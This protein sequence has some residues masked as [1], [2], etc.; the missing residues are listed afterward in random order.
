MQITPNMSDMTTNPSPKQQGFYMPAEWVRHEATWLTYPHNEE[1]WPGKIETIFN[2]Y[3]LFIKVLAEDERVCINVLN[4]AMRQQVNEDLHAIGV[5]MDRITLCVTP[6]ND[7]WCRDHG[8]AFLLN[9][10]SSDRYAIVNWNYNAWGGK[11]PCELDNQVPLH[12]ADFLNRVALAS[13]APT[14]EI[15]NP[16]IVME[17]GSI[18][19]N[20]CGDLLT[21]T[22]CLL[23][24][25]R[26][27]H[28][29]QNQI[30]DYLCDFYGAENVIW[31]GDGIVGDDT[32]GHVD[33]LSRFIN[34][35]TIITA[36]EENKWDENYDI[37]QSNLKMLNSCRLANGKQPTVVELPMPDVVS[38][39]GQR[40]PASYANFYIANNKVI[41]PTYRCVTDNRAAYI[42]EEC[43]PE[44]Y[45]VGIDSTDIIWGLGSFHCLSQ[46]QP[47]LV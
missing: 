17:G 32:D 21:T 12:I 19:V 22:S 46:Q 11:Y 16:G 1:S 18:D 27:P 30:T 24:P 38:Y 25:N 2:S 29:S 35:D 26:N 4:E 43:F 10:V 47:L 42:L 6:N 20:G 9:R 41:F 37:L 40:L 5:N 39:D 34:P 36:V 44:R 13:G 14:I 15:F 8:P 3:N 28:L 33:D 31:L 23:N 7:A 45:V